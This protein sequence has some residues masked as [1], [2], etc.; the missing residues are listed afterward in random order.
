MTYC[1]PPA[2]NVIGDAFKLLPI[3]EMPKSLAGLRVEPD[4]IAIVIG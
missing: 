2:L 4:K 3:V 1:L